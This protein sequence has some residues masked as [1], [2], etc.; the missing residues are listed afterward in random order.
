MKKLHFE[1]F[2]RFGYN[3]DL[4]EEQLIYLDQ[5]NYDIQQIS[6]LHP[7]SS[8]A[9]R[10]SMLE[11]ESRQYCLQEGCQFEPNHPLSTKCLYHTVRDYIIENGLYGFAQHIT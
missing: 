1:V 5:A 3:L 9:V 2:L 11:E 7:I 8:T 10:L 6:T 4:S